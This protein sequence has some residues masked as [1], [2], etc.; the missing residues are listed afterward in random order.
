[1]TER[2]RTQE[3]QQALFQQ[4]EARFLAEEERRRAEA[5]SRVAQEANRAKDAFLMTLSHEL[6]TPLTAI[7]GW[8]RLLPVLPPQEPSFRDAVA[9]IGRAAELQARL[10]DDVL[11]VSRIISGKLRLSVETVDA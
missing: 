10:I 6:R 7:L 2:K 3:M 8:S 1:M 9:A 4:R 5:S 11:D